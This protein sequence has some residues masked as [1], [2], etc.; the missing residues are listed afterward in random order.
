LKLYNS[1]ATVADLEACL[2]LAVRYLE[3]PDVLAITTNMALP[4]ETVIERIH[5]A[6]KKAGNQ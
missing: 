6:L 3:H 4:G 2:K 5:A 1:Q